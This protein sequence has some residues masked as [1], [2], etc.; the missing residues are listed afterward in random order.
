MASI[1]EKLWEKYLP[2]AYCSL[3]ARFRGKVDPRYN[4][5]VVGIA[6]G[7]LPK[8]ASLYARSRDLS[9]SRN[10]LCDGGLIAANSPTCQKDLNFC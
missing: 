3:Y 10:Q 8:A 1:A 5:W 7:K 4:P 6:T 9:I 2:D